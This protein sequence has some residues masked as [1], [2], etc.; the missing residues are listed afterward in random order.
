VTSKRS[1]FGWWF[2]ASDVLPNGDGRK[3]VIGETLTIDGDPRCC[4]KGLHASTRIIDALQYAPGP[5]IY[6]VRLSGQIDKE[7]DKLAASERTALW[8]VDGTKILREFA[9]LV[10][11]D[12][13]LVERKAGREPHPDSWRAVEVAL[14][15]VRGKATDQ[16]RSAAWSAA[17]SAA[18]S[19][20]RSAAWRAAESAAESAAWSAAWKRQN[21]KLT[22]LVMAA[23]KVDN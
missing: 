17:E 4:A 15:F 2:A 6:R 5:L 16:E 9:A 20:A 10:A 23:H 12:A 13:L 22:S 7:D 3:V 19:A 18:R 1:R 14:L 8:V 21:T 11:K